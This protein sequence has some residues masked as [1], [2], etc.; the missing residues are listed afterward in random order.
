VKKN[1]NALEGTG[2]RCYGARSAVT[3]DVIAKSKTSE[4]GSEGTSAM[5]GHLGLGNGLMGFAVGL[6]VHAIPGSWWPRWL[7]ELVGKK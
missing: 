6:F 4:R 7:R 1:T 5:N 3:E 2:S